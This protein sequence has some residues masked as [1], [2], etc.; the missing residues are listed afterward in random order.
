MKVVLFCGGLGTRLRESGGR[1]LPKPLVQIGYRPIIWH[2]MKYYAHFGHTDFIL[3]LGHGAALIKEYFL[4]YNEWV[5]NNFTLSEGG[6]KIELET[7]D[8]GNWRIQFVDTG[9]RSNIGERLM[10]VQP[11]LEG[12]EMFLANYSDGLTDM[13]L[14]DQVEALKTSGKT[15]TLLAV[16]PPQSFHVVKFNGD[17]VVKKI[18]SVSE[19]DVIING[20]YFVFRKEIFD[21]MREGEELVLEPFSRLIEKQELLAYRYANYWCMDT[22]KEQAE[23]TDLFEAGNPPWA[24]WENNK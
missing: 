14:P 2:V 5:S 18:E 3:C 12:E 13:H 1:N 22:F 9:R 7:S 20:G 8:I 24:V 11:Y 6:T 16:R 17:K 10:A 15:A 21:Y 4:T 19:S 23:L